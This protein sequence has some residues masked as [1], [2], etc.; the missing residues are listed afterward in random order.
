VRQG[1]KCPDRGLGRDWSAKSLPRNNDD[2]EPRF[3][4]TR[5]SRGSPLETIVTRACGGYIHAMALMLGK[6]YTAL[7]E[8]G[9]DA[10]KAR[11]ASEE[12]ATYENRIANIEAKLT[13]LIWMAGF[14][15]VMT[16]T[17]IGKEFLG[18]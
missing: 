1:R 15:L 2:R 11:G 12:V 8:A 3:S 16:V 18:H 14:N 7:R 5:E 10:D 9:V 4:L 17:L 6:L 13:V